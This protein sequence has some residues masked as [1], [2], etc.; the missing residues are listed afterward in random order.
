MTSVNIELGWVETSFT[1]KHDPRT[2]AR[3][4]PLLQEFEPKDELLASQDADDLCVL[5]GFRKLLP[6]ANGTAYRGVPLIRNHECRQ[7]HS[8]R[9]NYIDPRTAV[10]PSCSWWALSIESLNI[11]PTKRR[12]PV[13][14]G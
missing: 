14:L 13:A 11:V 12:D 3:Y 6:K 4:S 9:A 7:P 8:I 5:W 10:E 2:L 1:S